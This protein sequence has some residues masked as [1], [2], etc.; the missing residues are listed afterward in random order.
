MCHLGLKL[1][2]FRAVVGEVRPHGSPSLLMFGRTETL[3]G[4]CLHHG[5]KRVME[6]SLPLLCCRG[7]VARF[8][9]E[10]GGGGARWRL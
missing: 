8:Y 10:S 2:L 5:I 1:L 7:Q 4:I 3:P 6:P 9:L